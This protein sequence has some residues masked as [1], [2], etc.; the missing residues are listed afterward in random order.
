MS[1]IRKKLYSR[2]PRWFRKIKAAII[3]LSDSAVIIFIGIG[4]AENSLLILLLR[5]GISAV[6]QTAEIILSNET[7]E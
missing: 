5:V 2:A 6:L 4:Y 1:P 7:N 3:L